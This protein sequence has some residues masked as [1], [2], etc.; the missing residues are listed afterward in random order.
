MYVFFKGVLANS[1][2]CVRGKLL[3]D[4]G[5]EALT[6]VHSAI[7]PDRPTGNVQEWYVNQDTV[8]HIYLSDKMYYTWINF[9][10]ITA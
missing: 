8:Q 5:S 4:P 7:T 3:P 2:I 10:G 1:G 9:R 6:H